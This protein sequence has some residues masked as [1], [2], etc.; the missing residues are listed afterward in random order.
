MFH[1]SKKLNEDIEKKF[2]S[3]V[4]KFYVRKR[5][6]LEG[7]LKREGYRFKLPRC[8]KCNLPVLEYNSIIDD[9]I[10]GYGWCQT[11]LCDQG[12][13]SLEEEV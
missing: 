1:I 11:V 8:P 5:K 7:R 10:I 9:R 6:M 2:Y 12:A 3:N 4:H 13:F